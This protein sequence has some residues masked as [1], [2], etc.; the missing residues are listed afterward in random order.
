MGRDKAGVIVNGPA[1]HELD[2][3]YGPGCFGGVAG[4]A[5]AIGRALRL[6]IQSTQ[7]ARRSGAIAT[8][9][10]TYTIAAARMTERSIPTGWAS[11]VSN[12]FENGFSIGSEV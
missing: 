12:C 11:S 3:P 2:I 9:R 10:K 5:P 8:L 6:V 7:P 1:R 4:P